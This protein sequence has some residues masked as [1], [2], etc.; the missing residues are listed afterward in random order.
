MSVQLKGRVP[1]VNILYKES[2]RY[3]TVSKM[4]LLRQSIY[5][6]EYSEIII[7]ARTSFYMNAFASDYDK[8]HF[9]DPYTFNPDRYLGDVD[10][11]PHYAYGAGS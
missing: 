6:I 2:P 5:G 4:S 7:R 9:E 1:Y 11:T 8:N 3:Y 10:G